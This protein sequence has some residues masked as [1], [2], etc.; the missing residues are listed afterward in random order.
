MSTIQ[1]TT[2]T[3]PDANTPLILR[4]A[5]TSAATITLSPTNTDIM[6]SGTLKD[7]TVAAAFGKANTALQNTSGIL[8][9]SLYVTGNLSSGLSSTTFPIETISDPTTAISLKIRGRS[10][11]NDSAI[12]WYSNDG[13]TQ[14]GYV[15]FGGQAEISVVTNDHLIVKTNSTT[16]IKVDASGNT[17]FGAAASTSPRSRLHTSA[18]GTILDMGLGYVGQNTSF[19][20]TNSDISYGLVGGVGGSGDTYLQSQRIDGSATAYN[21]IL[22]NYGGNVAIGG[23]SA[24][25]T[26]D[27]GN[28][29]DAVILPTGT[30]AQR[31]SSPVNG[32]IRKSSTS[33]AVEYYDGITSSWMLLSGYPASDPYFSTT[34]VLVK[35]GSS[36]DYSS[37]ARTLTATNISPSTSVG[38]PPIVKTGSSGSVGQVWY[39]NTGTNNY[40]GFGGSLSDFNLSQTAWTLEFW[41]YIPSGSS[42]YLHTFVVGGQ[43]GGGVFKAYGGDGYYYLY[44]GAGASASLSSG[45]RNQWFWVVFERYNGVI[46]AWV[47]GANRVQSSSMPTGGTPGSAG[48]GL[49]F[50]NEYVGHYLDEVRFTTTARYQ[51]AASIP[52]QSYSWP[53]R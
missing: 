18:S 44:S 9:G 38:Y 24:R 36:T 22:Q 39:V 4:S 10:S 27:L 52:V 43:S 17:G 15:Q 7:P 13:V 32:M 49:P 16:R 31:P 42:S 48:L 34:K 5:N 3:S 29:T 50:N 19:Y 20:M 8:S 53:E 40:L 45:F 47:N 21:I 1:V 2:V 25:T 46:S 33:S 23:T 30:V 14:Q 41:A 6:I 37:V 12:R 28:R 26:L 11:S 35:N 51:G